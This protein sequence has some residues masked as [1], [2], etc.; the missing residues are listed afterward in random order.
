M[1][2]DHSEPPAPDPEDSPERSMLL[3]GMDDQGSSEQKPDPPVQVDWGEA[4]GSHP[5]TIPCAKHGLVTALVCGACHEDLQAHAE[6]LDRARETAASALLEAQEDAGEQRNQRDQYHA[7]AKE[8]EARLT[9]AVERA[10]DLEESSVKARTRMQ[11]A[12]TQAKKALKGTEQLQ[13]HA[14]AI[15]EQHRATHH[16][17]LEAQALASEACAILE[18][19]GVFHIDDPDDPM[20]SW[21]VDGHS[22]AREEVPEAVRSAFGETRNEDADGHVV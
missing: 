9:A 14:E 4:P 17:L 8:A 11:D 12:E 16:R 7:K 10:S 19:L 18:T 13:N 15:E 20:L 5:L 22:Y 21:K 1:Q 2:I 6:A 3:D